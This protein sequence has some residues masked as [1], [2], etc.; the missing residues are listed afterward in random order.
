MHPTVAP[1]EEQH[2]VPWHAMEAEAVAASLDTAQDTGLSQAAAQARLK[3]Y[4]PNLPPEAVPRSGLSML[5][6]QFTSLPVALLGAAA[7]IALLTGGVADALV[8]AGA[9][10]L[11]A[12]IGYV[13]ES[14]T[15]QT[16]HALTSLVR[17]STQVLREGDLCTV[18]SEE[19]VPGDVLLLRP[20]SYV[21]ADARVC[22]AERLSVDESTLT[23]ES[24]PVAKTSASLADAKIPLCE[25]LSQPG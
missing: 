9:V 22:T 6:E 12:A 17:P 8:I 5:L 21:P 20:G 14:Q 16:I 4:G 25:D 3:R 11:N 23:G 13:T 10:V 18:R 2:E 15:E 24:L 19:V 7:G 1:P